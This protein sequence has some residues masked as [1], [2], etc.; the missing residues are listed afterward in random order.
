MAQRY[1]VIVVGPGG[2]GSSAAYHLAARGQRVLG[3]E[4]FGPA[5]DQGSSHGGSRIT[6]QSYFEDPAYV[7]LLLHTYE[8]WDRLPPH[9]GQNPIP[10][11]RRPFLREPGTPAGG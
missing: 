9:P 10:P 1:A 6:R 5:H 7:P 3:L 4:R 11:P 8:L 2:M